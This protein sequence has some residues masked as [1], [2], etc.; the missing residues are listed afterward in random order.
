MLSK[1][2]MDVQRSLNVKSKKV[3]QSLTKKILLHV[4]VSLLV[5][6]RSINLKRHQI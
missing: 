4:L 2:S 6:P 3:L 5:I 1:P